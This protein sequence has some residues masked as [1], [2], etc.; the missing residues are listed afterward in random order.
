MINCLVPRNLT[1]K[2]ISFEISLMHT[3]GWSP[4]D[5]FLD[6]VLMVKKNEGGTMSEIV[7]R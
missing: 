3:L 5:C 2:Q 4:W 7:N 6:D 1:L